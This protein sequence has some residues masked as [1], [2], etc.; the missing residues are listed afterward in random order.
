MVSDCSGSVSC[1]ESSIF[2]I[3]SACAIN[4][5]VSG[6]IQRFAMT[7]L[8]NEF[9]RCSVLSR[10]LPSV[11]IRVSGTVFHISSFVASSAARIFC[12]CLYKQKTQ[13]R[14]SFPF[15]SSF[16]SSFYKRFSLGQ[17]VETIRPI[18]V[19]AKTCDAIAGEVDSEYER[20]HC[21]VGRGCE[22]RG[23]V[24]GRIDTKCCK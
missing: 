19:K 23:L 16:F 5:K 12:L 4:V 13:K 3:D 14:F 24:I 11:R 7:I 18:S 6:L 10:C 1:I 15:C 8:V 2:H 9:A 17:K 21:A 22:S 20:Q